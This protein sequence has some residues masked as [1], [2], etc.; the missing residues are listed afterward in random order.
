M[1]VLLST[2]LYFPAATKCLA[3]PV[4]IL[5]QPLEAALE[6]LARQSGI[7]IL[8]S[9]SSVQGKT[10]P[11]VAGDMNPKDALTALLVGSGLKPA[12]SGSG[13][14]VVPETEPAR[15]AARPAPDTAKTA[16]LDDLDEVVVKAGKRL[17]PAATVPAAISVLEGETLKSKG[18]QT[19][20]DVPN[21]DPNF[22]VNVVAHG[23][24]M[25]IRGVANT[26]NTSKG[27]QSIPYYLDGVTLGHP[28]EES[29][30][31]FDI[32]HIDILRGPQGTQFGRATAGGAVNVFT[33]QPTD[34]YEAYAKLDFGNF[35]T[36]REET[37]VN[38]PVSDWLWL[39][40]AGSFNN[41]EGYFTPYDDGQK[42][43]D[44]DDGA[45][46]LSALARLGADA[47][48]RLTLNG[49]HVG[50]AGPGEALLGT[51]LSTESSQAIRTNFPKPIHANLNDTFYDISAQLDWTIGPVRLTYVGARQHFDADE[52]TSDNNDPAGNDNAYN[53]AIYRASI[54]SNQHEARVAN[55]VP[56]FVDYVAGLTYLGESLNEHDH[57]LE[58]P[59]DDPTMAASYN[60]LDIIGITTHSSYGAF[61][62][63]TAH[64]TD[65]I[66]L[67]GG[68]RFQEDGVKRVGTLAPKP[69]NNGL[70]W[71]N[72]AGGV[73][74]GAQDCIGNPELADDKAGR[75]TYRAAV[76]FQA[77]P[78]DLLYVSVA[79]GYK[80]GGFNDLDPKT[81]R[82]S[83]YGP[84]S[85]TSYE[86]GY[87]GDVLEKLRLSSD[88]FYYDYS[89]DQ[90]TS[91]IYL[92]PPVLYTQLVPATIYG[93]ENEATWRLSSDTLVKLGVTFERSHFGPIVTG[94]QENADW[95]GQSLD[96]VPLLVGSMEIQH[97]WDLPD[98]YRLFLR[99]L[100]KASTSYL[101]SDYVL[102]YRYRQPG[103]TRSDLTASLVAP[104]DRW[105]LQAYVQN[106]E[107]RLQAIGQ[108]QNV[109]LSALQGSYVAVTTPRLFGVRL[110]VR[111]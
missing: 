35:G 11:G 18:V 78:V 90:I 22:G 9:P 21:V 94:Y 23:V 36:H 7:Q 77:T 69:T 41:H 20:A 63:A 75:L 74:T 111:Y 105:E 33:R 30:A 16:G 19:V 73:C 80:P 55:A 85:M 103:Y 82:P 46:R 3:R 86:I 108:P 51:L 88:F 67:V 2:A 81:Q 60:N 31:F 101:V 84:E 59:V 56:A 45:G 57:Q 106:I 64:V 17:D 47:T 62:Q 13:Y 100:T 99:G 76:N 32:D 39:R 92:R 26:D 4:E 98:S 44:Q 28:I 70:P 14:I 102:P 96:R 61:G 50:G 71:L 29:L 52:L 93:W 91:A 110:T 37:A 12:Q 65:R 68:L 72:G 38:V 66:D 15:A 83:N 54:T 27:A 34:N 6:E 49:G 79:S 43:G 48:L 40:A 8:F 24:S 87:K 97:A 104:G 1:T 53:W 42:K 95:T 10:S 5:P 107:D 25:T 109:N 89:K 58:A